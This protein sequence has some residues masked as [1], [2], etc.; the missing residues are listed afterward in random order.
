M[1]SISLLATV[2]F[3]LKFE[4]RAIFRAFSFIHS[5]NSALV[6]ILFVIIGNLLLK[7]TVQLHGWMKK[8]LLWTI[9]IFFLLANILFPYDNSVT[10]VHTFNYEMPTHWTTLFGWLI[11]EKMYKKTFAFV[12]NTTTT[13]ESIVKAVNLYYFWIK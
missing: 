6:L 5:K 12:S 2:K 3:E 1:R 7:L 11:G 9:W 13:F 8:N 10:V 4:K